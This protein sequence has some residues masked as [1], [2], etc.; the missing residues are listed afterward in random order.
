MRRERRSL[1][2]PGSNSRTNVPARQVCHGRSELL[3]K[4]EHAQH[5]GAEGGQQHLQ[6]NDGGRPGCVETAV[7]EDDQIKQIGQAK[8]KAKERAYMSPVDSEARYSLPVSVVISRNLHDR[9]NVLNFL[10]NV[11]KLFRSS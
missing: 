6:L 9:V 3:R 4:E 10:D 5:D 8:S 7:Q 11:G 1:S 2:E